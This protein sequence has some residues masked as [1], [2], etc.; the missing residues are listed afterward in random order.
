MLLLYAE[1]MQHLGP[2]DEYFL[3]PCPF[4]FSF[5]LNNLHFFFT[6]FQ[7]KTLAWFLFII[8]IMAKISLSKI[9]FQE[10]CCCQI[11]QTEY[12]AKCSTLVYNCHSLNESKILSLA[13][14]M[15][16]I[17]LKSKKEF[18]NSVG[19]SLHE[20]KLQECLRVPYPG[21]RHVQWLTKVFLQILS[22][23]RLHRGSWI[24][25]IAASVG[26]YLPETGMLP[27]FSLI[28]HYKN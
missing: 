4:E 16:C 18:S 27:S 3:S 21:K 10:Q 28:Y 8:K 23:V 2:L 11:L 9:S 19:L 14:K 15:A 25:F 22:K 7:R 20:Q 12:V 5:N 13:L 6:S 1:S 26:M 24:H 17:I